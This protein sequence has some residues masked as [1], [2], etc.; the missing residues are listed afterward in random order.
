MFNMT[1]SALTVLTCFRR[2]GFTGFI[3]SSKAYSEMPYHYSTLLSW[4][5]LV[6]DYFN[7]RIS[8]SN[9]LIDLRPVLNVKIRRG[10]SQGLRLNTAEGDMV[11]LQRCAESIPPEQQQGEQRTTASATSVTRPP[12]KKRKLMTNSTA[13][14]DMML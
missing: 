9:D 14:E 10:G 5:N 13:L 8:A 6:S 7:S 11:C 3:G 4:N 2:N 1:T 12:M